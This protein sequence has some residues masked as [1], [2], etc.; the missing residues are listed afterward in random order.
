MSQLLVLE[1]S[2]TIW[3]GY[4]NSRHEGVTLNY[5]LDA[6]RPVYE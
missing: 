3:L 1:R 6:C 2:L 4:K 5:Y